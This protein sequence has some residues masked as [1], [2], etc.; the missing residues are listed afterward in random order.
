MLALLLVLQQANALRLG[1]APR[2]IQAARAA[3][4]M[5]NM[6]DVGDEKKTDAEGDALAAAFAKRLEQ[7]GG[8][9]QFKIKTGI[10]DM[11][12]SITDA[13]SSAKNAAANA[14]YDVKD[15]GSSITTASPMALIGGLFAVTL[16]LTVLGNLNSGASVDMGTSDG[17]ALQFGQRTQSSYSGDIPLSAYQP[18]YGS[19]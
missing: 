15:A 9:T 14:A 4:P 12:E 1:T 5:L 19:Q 7:E 6:D 13:A 8:A 2:H 10:N 3:P 11:K 18:E 16:A 17:Q